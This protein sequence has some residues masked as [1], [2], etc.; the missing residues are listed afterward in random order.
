MFKLLLELLR[1][2]LLQVSTIGVVCHLHHRCNKLLA[3]HV[4]QMG[5]LLIFCRFR[6]GKYLL[7]LALQR[8][9]NIAVYLITEYILCRSDNKFVRKLHFTVLINR[10]VFSRFRRYIDQIALRRVRQRLDNVND[11][12]RCI[13]DICDILKQ[14]IR[15][16]A[17]ADNFQRSNLSR[18][19]QHFLCIQLDHLAVFVLSDDREKVEQFT[20][21][22]LALVAVTLSARSAAGQIIRKFLE[23][24]QRSCRIK[25]EYIGILLHMKRAVLL[26]APRILT[27][28]CRLH[29]QRRR[30]DIGEHQHRRPLRNGDTRG[31]LSD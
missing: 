21:I 30:F 29:I 23:D 22:L 28:E 11:L 17:T 13:E 19:R 15:H 1:I 2:T 24:D 6:G 10:K 4:L 12:R 8:F 27:A 18:N 9:G 7:G 20:D 3:E 31:Q 16:K 5:Y 14:E 25:V 26:I